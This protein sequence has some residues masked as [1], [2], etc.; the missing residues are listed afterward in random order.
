MLA[1]RT[2]R[3]MM[4]V[5]LLTEISSA[6]DKFLARLFASKY[7]V[8]ETLGDARTHLYHRLMLT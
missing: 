7:S 1:V 8:E 6:A 5:L 2:S 3:T 4:S